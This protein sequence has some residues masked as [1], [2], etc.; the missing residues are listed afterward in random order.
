MRHD[1]ITERARSSSMSREA[2]DQYAA[3]A[4]NAIPRKPDMRLDGVHHVTAITGDGCGNRTFYT[5]LFGL[6]LI[7][8]LVSPEDPAVEQLLYGSEYGQPGAGIAF[9]IY[10]GAI[11]GRAGGA[12][13]TGFRG[14]SDAREHLSS[15]ATACSRPVAPMLTLRPLQPE[16]R[17]QRCEGR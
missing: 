8:R 4:G 13:S 16:H 12:W 1:L 9:L 11:R 15:G 14:A 10:K 17:R 5:D 3:P 7:A 6:R 2:S